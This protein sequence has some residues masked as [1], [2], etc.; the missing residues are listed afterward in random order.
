MNQN[1]TI[2]TV[3]LSIIGAIL[4]VWLYSVCWYKGLSRDMVSARDQRLRMSIES[5]PHFQ[6]Q[7][8]PRQRRTDSA[9]ETNKRTNEEWGSHQDQFT[10][11]SSRGNGQWQGKKKNKGKG[12][13]KDKQKEKGDGWGH[14]DKPKEDEQQQEEWKAVD[15]MDPNAQKTNA[16]SDTSGPSDSGTSVVESEWNLSNQADKNSTSAA[17]D[18]GT[19]SAVLDEWGRSKQNDEN[20]TSGPSDSGISAVDDE[21]G[22]TEH[23]HNNSPEPSVQEDTK[24][25]R[26]NRGNTK[27]SQ[28][29][30]ANW[31]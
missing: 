22:R 31:W 10:G 1:I 30:S 11:E 12:K 13:E 5:L 3:I 7:S 16:N 29:P 2:L 6:T 21:W 4:L 18:T 9:N 23:V 27:S 28:D 14:Q 15:G 20:S 25:D 24:D 8:P 17:S 19:S 26:R